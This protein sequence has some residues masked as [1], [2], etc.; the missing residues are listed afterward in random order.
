MSIPEIDSCLMEYLFVLAQLTSKFVALIFQKSNILY[1]R[2]GS[3]LCKN[4]LFELRSPRTI[5]CVVN[6]F[7]ILLHLPLLCWMSVA[8]DQMT[9]VHSSDYDVRHR[10]G[11]FA[12]CGVRKMVDSENVNC[13]LVSEYR[14]ITQPNLSLGLVHSPCLCMNC[15]PWE[16]MSC[17]PTVW[18][19]WAL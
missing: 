1:C 14:C 2:M 12:S 13:E 16:W 19:A 3:Q 7:E 15:L 10:I 8:G 5:S 6:H 9:R 17:L 4:L 11:C 18:S